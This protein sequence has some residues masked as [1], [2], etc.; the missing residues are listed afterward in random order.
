MD[1]DDSTEYGK[2]RDTTFQT[3]KYASKQVA[4][5]NEVVLLD[6]DYQSNDWRDGDYQNSRGFLEI[7]VKKRISLFDVN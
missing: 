5:G 7:L 6:S 1:A 4:L 2:K 3:T